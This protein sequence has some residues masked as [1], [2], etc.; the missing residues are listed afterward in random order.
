M[1]KIEK[2]G[3]YIT[4][5]GYL[6]L[7][8]SLSM[9]YYS[10]NYIEYVSN[11]IFYISILIIISGISF[12]RINTIKKYMTVNKINEKNQQNISNLIIQLYDVETIKIIEQQKLTPH[13]SINFLSD[14]YQPKTEF[15]INDFQ[16]MM[17][18]KNK[19][20]VIA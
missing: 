11:Y 5:A 13:I 12:G 14:D 10:D 17:T 6:I 1:T 16:P 2:A 4:I 19:C 9:N 18:D 8:S 20:G 15:K 7:A 3:Y